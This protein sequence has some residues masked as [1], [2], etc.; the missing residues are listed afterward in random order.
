MKL[1][2]EEVQK[3]MKERM[4]RQRKPAVDMGGEENTLTL[5]RLWLGLVPW[6]PPRTVGNQTSFNQILQK[7]L[8]DR[9]SNPVALDSARRQ[10]GP[11]R[12]SDP[13]GPLP[14]RLRRRLLHTLQRH[15][16]LLPHGSG[17]SSN[18]ATTPRAE[19]DAVEKTEE[20]G[21]E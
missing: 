11:R 10:A 4:G 2:P 13:A 14:F 19:A 5:P 18:G 6:K 17:S 15:R 7:L 20:E 8:L 9:G 21:E 12:G 3:A 1:S 16:L